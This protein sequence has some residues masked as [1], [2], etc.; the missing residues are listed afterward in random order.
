MSTYPQVVLFGSISGGWRERAVIPVLERL[1][2]TYFNPASGG[3]WTP[4]MG[5]REGEAMAHA[6]TILMVFTNDLPSFTGLAETGWAALGAVERGQ[7]FILCLPSENFRANTPWYLRWSGYVQR[8]TRLFNHYA[9][10]SRL[11]VREHAAKFTHP[12]IHV[13]D[14]LEEAVTLLRQRYA[15]AQ[16]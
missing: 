14:S 4:E 5:R 3:D 7:L 12:N 16:S 13:V 15:V 2:V 11:L 6:E 9:K 1:G 8:I 10:S